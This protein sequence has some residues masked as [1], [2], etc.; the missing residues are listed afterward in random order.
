MPWVR[1]SDDFYWIQ[2]GFTI[3]YKAGMHLNVTRA[4]AA[5]AIDKGKAVAAKR[6]RTTD[7]EETQ[8]RPHARTAAL[9]AAR[10]NT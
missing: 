1:F 8:R 4:C 3:A 9:P 2:P 5:E 6:K 10:C 7:G